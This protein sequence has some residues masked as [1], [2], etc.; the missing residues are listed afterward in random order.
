MFIILPFGMTLMPIAYKMFKKEGDKHYYSKL[1]T[2]ASFIF[3]WIGLAISIFSEDI[4]KLF[5]L[6]SSFYSAFTIVPLVVLAYVIYG[7]SMI[8]ALG[9][10][11]TG[12]SHLIGFRLRHCH[13]CQLAMIQVQHTPL[14]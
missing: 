2:Y 3:I 11:L 6:N 13:K 10:Y 12:K 4:V 5:A 14:T 8:S 7:V 1:K 9:M